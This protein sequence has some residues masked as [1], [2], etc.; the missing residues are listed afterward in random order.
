M[1]G[2]EST[3]PETRAELI[4]PAEPEPA[5]EEHPPTPE[6]PPAEGAPPSG[7]CADSVE[8]PLIE[9]GNPGMEYAAITAEELMCPPKDPGKMQIA[10]EWLI[11]E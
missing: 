4:P 6:S 1:P 3:A 9:S 11:A 8:W 10:K 2:P 7:G 5:I